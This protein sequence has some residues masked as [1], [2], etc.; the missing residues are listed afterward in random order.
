MGIYEILPK[1]IVH[2]FVQNGGTRGESTQLIFKE[3]IKNIQ[4][5]FIL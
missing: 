1:C 5:Y 4:C 2:N 3:N